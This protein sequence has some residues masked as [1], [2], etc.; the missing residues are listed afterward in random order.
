MDQEKVA[1]WKE[2]PLSFFKENE[3]ELVLTEKACTEITKYMTE[4]R[5]RKGLNE[6]RF[7]LLQVIY[8]R[9]K[10]RLGVKQMRQGDVE[11]LT[12]IF[13]ESGLKGS[14]DSDRVSDWIDQGNRI[15]E[16]CLA[17]GSTKRTGYGHLANLF[18]FDE[19]SYRT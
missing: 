13:F 12:Q 6:V 2:A 15:N 10:E 17:V 16:L 9:F 5:D 8:Y 19:I 3:S 14:N 18:F 4:L 11:C 7:R 1:L